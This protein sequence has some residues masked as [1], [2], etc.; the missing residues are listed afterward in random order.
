M[1]FIWRGDSSIE[2][3][4]GDTERGK[5]WHGTGKWKHRAQ[6]PHRGN[7]RQFSPSKCVGVRSQSGKCPVE[8]SHLPPPSLPFDEVEVEEQH[9]KRSL[10]S[11]LSDFHF[12][13]KCM[14]KSCW[15]HVFA[16]CRCSS[17]P[18]CRAAAS[19]CPPTCRRRRASGSGPP[20]SRAAAGGAAETGRVGQSKS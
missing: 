14:L 9:Y 4:E 7:G 3:I 16:C 15:T 11:Q 1:D 8:R 20:S 17:P 5:T 19:A 18:R 2:T 10:P 6:R 13:A 12:S